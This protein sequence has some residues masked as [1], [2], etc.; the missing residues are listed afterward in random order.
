MFQR[1]HTIARP[2]TKACRC[3]K[4]MLLLF[5]QAP[6][7]AL[8]F[9]FLDVVGNQTV[10]KAIALGGHASEKQRVPQSIPQEE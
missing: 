5:P 1:R 3:S 9:D 2:K 7:D 8:Y 10:P 4:E 6:A